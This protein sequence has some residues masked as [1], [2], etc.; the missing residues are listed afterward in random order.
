MQD[1]DSYAERTVGE[2]KHV[3][4]R[5]QQL[6]HAEGLHNPHVPLALS[7]HRAGDQSVVRSMQRIVAHRHQ[8]FIVWLLLNHR[9]RS[10]MYSVSAVHV[11]GQ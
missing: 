6:E 10:N 5:C 7:S 11:H 4:H 8:C 1:R 2:L 9:T 3:S